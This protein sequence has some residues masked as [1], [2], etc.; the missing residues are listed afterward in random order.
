MGTKNYII[1]CN[2]C[3]RVHTY[4]NNKNSKN[5]QQIQ[6]KFCRECENIKKATYDYGESNAWRRQ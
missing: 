5:N 3:Y 6:V 4:L 1:H 2:H